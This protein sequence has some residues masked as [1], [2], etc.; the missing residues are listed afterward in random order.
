MASGNDMRWG[1]SIPE[2]TYGTRVAPTRFFGLNSEDVGYEFNRYFSPVLGTGRWARPSIVTTSAGTGS[3]TGDVPTTGFG[4]LLNGLHNNTVTPTIQGAGPAMLQT[5]TL[6]T[7]VARSYTI[8]VQVPPV[9][10]STLLPNDLYGCVFGG[11]TFSWDPGEVLRFELPI[12]ARELNTAQTLATYTPPAAYN[13][14][15]FKG[16]Q[17]LVGGTPEANV[18]GG[19]NM[20]IAYNLRDDAFALGSS[21]L[22]AKP[23][24]TDKPTATG[25][26]TADFNDLTNLN[27]VTGDTSADVIL[28]FEGITLN[29]TFKEMLEVTIPDAKFTSPRP[30]VGGPGPVQQEVS[31]SNASSTG[32]A[33][34]IKYIS[35]DSVL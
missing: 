24:E 15:S 27:R 2:T 1:I 9:N 31:F 22:M 4:W 16:G 20:A 28:R 12:I 30:T 14:L 17:I 18:V 11:V 10:T 3:I 13:L 32:D 21:G 19:G 29:A 35:T 7:P 33:V 25:T 34:V 6:D 26:F 23:V 5:H 8:Q